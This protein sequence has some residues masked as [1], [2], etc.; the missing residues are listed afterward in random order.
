MKTVLSTLYAADGRHSCTKFSAFL[1]TLTADGNVV[2][3]SGNRNYSDQHHVVLQSY[4][5]QQ[6]Q[7]NLA[8]LLLR[9]LRN[10]S[11]QSPWFVCSSIYSFEQGSQNR[12]C[13]KIL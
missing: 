3:K 2:G 5:E 12:T 8:C 7:A 13:N 10:D 4:K 11:S 9:I 1:K 6:I